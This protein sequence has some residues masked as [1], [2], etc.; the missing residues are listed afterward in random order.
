MSING[1]V[2]HSQEDTLWM[3]KIA[4]I[5]KLQTS[6]ADHILTDEH[7]ERLIQIYNRYR[8][9][10]SDTPSK[11]KNFQCEIKFK[12][13]IRDRYYIVAPNV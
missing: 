11:I 4:E 8:H 12:M 9:V 5:K 3:E 2:R 7:I 13:C 6:N 1:E 10:F